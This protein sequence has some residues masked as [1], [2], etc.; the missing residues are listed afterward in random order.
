MADQSGNISRR[1]VLA[2]MAGVGLG[3]AIGDV[4]DKQHRPRSIP[5]VPGAMSVAGL[6]QWRPNILL[7]VNDQLRHWQDLPSGLGLSALEMLLEQGTGMM[8]FHANTTP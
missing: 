8:N 5:K 1:K 2:A 6:R 4:A 3:A 7:I